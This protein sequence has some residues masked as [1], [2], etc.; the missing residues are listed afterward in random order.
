MPTLDGALAFTEVHRPGL[1][2]QHLDLDVP[3]P[4]DVLL[5]ID[6][7]IAER[8][9]RLR[10]RSLQ[11]RAQL[12]WCAHHAHAAPTA[13]RRSLHH[14]RE[15]DFLGHQPR[16]LEVGDRGD[17]SRHHRHVGEL[18]PSARLGLVAHGAD[19]VSRRP[20][21]CQAGAGHGIG[22]R[23]PLREE[24]VPGMDRIS[25]TRSR[26]LEQARHIE[27]ALGCGR[28]A[29]MD[30]AIGRLH[31]RTRAV[32]V[33]VHG[34]GLDAILVTGAHDPQGDLP[35]VRNQDSFHDGLGVV[36]GDRRPAGS[37]RRRAGARGT[38]ARCSGKPRHRLRARRQ[39]T[40]M[41]RPCWPRVRR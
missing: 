18:H 40:R 1:V 12:T 22:E 13:T 41:R 37:L 25:A 20:D 11:C 26:R 32:G 5:E 21:P 30:G 2:G 23:R 36:R 34:D 15:P 9:L 31:M 4:L 3:R 8:L 10:G 14:Q 39:P 19:G 27:V 33:R 29:D 16:A 7:R 28:G 24:S 35:A 38:G 17:G 6:T